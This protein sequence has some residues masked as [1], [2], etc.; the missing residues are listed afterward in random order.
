MKYKPS[1]TDQLP[2]RTFLDRNTPQPFISY[3]NPSARPLEIPAAVRSEAVYIAGNP[4]SGK[5]SLLQHMILHDICEERGVCVIDPTADLVKKLLHW[6]PEQRANDTIYFDTNDPLPI[7]FFSYN[8]TLEG[9]RDI[10]TD[11]LL[12]ILGLDEAPISIRILE[13]ILGTLF[14]ANENGAHFTFLDIARFIESQDTRKEVW[15]FAPH[16]E[17]QWPEQKFKKLEVSPTLLERLSRFSER[18]TLRKIFDAVPVINISDIMRDKK[19]LLVKL[20]Q[21]PTDRFIGSLIFAK[22]L[23]ATLSREHIDLSEREPFFLYIDE[24][25]LIIRHAADDF[26][27]TLTQARKYNLC[28]TLANQL[29][30][31]SDFPHKIKQKLPMLGTVI[32]MRLDD[33]NM[34]KRRIPEDLLQQIPTLQKFT[35]VASLPCGSSLVDTPHFLGE[36]PHS[37]AEIILKR[38]VPNA[39]LQHPQG[40]HNKGNADRYREPEEGRAPTD[41]RQN[42]DD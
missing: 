40:Y 7:D 9:D 2:K 22:F 34:F 1:F 4:G 19:I 11:Q 33:P 39:S 29:P 20:K 25:Q 15:K 3:H 38:T 35:A 41:P 8:K 6:I 30:D 32:L 14:D 31:D 5:S 18:P 26:S 36:S 42:K 10:L 13:R 21:N 12:A 28:L 17:P 37:Y 23:Q 16:R 24:C 27:D